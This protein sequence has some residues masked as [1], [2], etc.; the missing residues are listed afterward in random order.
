LELIEH[1]RADPAKIDRLE[2]EFSIK[3]AADNADIGHDSDGHVGLGHGGG[4]EH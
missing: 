1:L 4:H 3:G 2:L